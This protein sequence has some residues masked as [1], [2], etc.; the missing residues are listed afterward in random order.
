MSRTTRLS[1]RRGASTP[2]R[3]EI[4]VAAKE[5]FAEHGYKSVSVDDIGEAVG[6]SGPGLY[7][8]FAS[9]T[10]LLLGV[11]DYVIE[12]L[13]EFAEEAAD[14]RDPV[15]RLEILVDAQIDF[16][17]HNQGWMKV[18]FHEEQNL[19]PKDREANRAEAWKY[20][21]YWMDALNK[22]QPGLSEMETRIAIFGCIG[23][24]N[25]RATDDQRKITA[26]ERP[27]LRR[28]ALA[29]LFSQR[30]N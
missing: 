27:S 1:S 23:L 7:R 9:K 5:L 28:A 16:A 2:R 19:D 15:R 3:Q 10:D 25:L 8:H 29:V 30:P 6:I 14:E 12:S 4:L 13:L 20:Y 11:Y 17:S 21:R 24:I 22:A 18:F 26:V